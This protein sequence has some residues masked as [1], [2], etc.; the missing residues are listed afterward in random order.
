MVNAGDC[1]ER[2]QTRRVREIMSFCSDKASLW[3]KIVFGIHRKRVVEIIEVAHRKREMNV[4]RRL[5]GLMYALKENRSSGGDDSTRKVK[6][7]PFRVSLK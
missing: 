4:P 6:V 5:K 1:T 3:G 7:K 2:R